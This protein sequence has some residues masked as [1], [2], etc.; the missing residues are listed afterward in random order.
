M[1][2]TQGHKLESS[3]QIGDN[4]VVSRYW[5][6]YRQFFLSSL[7]RE[8]EFRANF[9][10]KILQNIVWMVFFLLVILVIYRNTDHVAGWNRGQ[11]F[12][13]AATVFL[14]EAISRTL[15]NSLIEIPEQVRKGTLDFVVTKP[16]DCQFWI[17]MRRFNFDQI[18]SIVAGIG[19]LCYGVASSGIQTNAINWFGYL[20]L[21]SCAVV[22]YNSFMTILMTLGIWLVRVDNLWVLGETVQQVARYPIDIFQPNIRAFLTYG[23]PLAFIATMPALQL[24]KAPQWQVLLTGMVWAIAL[25]IVSRTYWTFAMKHYSSASS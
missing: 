10:A 13:L 8:L 24:M 25:F 20:I 19:M 5:R 14:L 16:I 23:L 21:F 12:V 7:Q 2:Y 4:N 6:I 11:A 1:D 22:I 9:I 3:N 15:F 17:T 18:G